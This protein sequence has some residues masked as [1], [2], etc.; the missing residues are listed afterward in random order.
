MRIHSIID[1]TRLK[2]KRHAVKIGLSCAMSIGALLLAG[3]GGGEN[4]ASLVTP[5]RTTLAEV[6]VPTAAM[7]LVRNS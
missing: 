3:C 2:R 4:D 5:T 1:I 6:H 7:Y